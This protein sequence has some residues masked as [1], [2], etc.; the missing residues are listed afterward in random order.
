NGRDV[1]YLAQNGFTACDPF[2]SERRKFRIF[3]L[4][5]AERALKLAITPLASEPLLACCAM[6]VNRL[7]VRPSCRKKMPWPS[8]QSGAERNW[9]PPAPPCE[10]LSFRPVPM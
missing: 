2:Y 5:V 1:L 8:P 6:A 7:A 4:L 9:S 10:T 3:C